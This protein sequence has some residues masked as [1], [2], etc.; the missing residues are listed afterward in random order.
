VRADYAKE[1]LKE[2]GPVPAEEP[3]L[4]MDK[5]GERLAFERAGARLYE[6]LLSKFDAYGSFP[7][8]PTRDDIAHILDEE[9]RH[10]TML[11]ELIQT[12][13]G[14]PTE[15]TPS[16]N[17]QLVASQGV[18]QVLVDPRTNLIQSLEA[19]AMAELTDNECWETLAGLARLAG[20]EDLAERCEDA[21]LTEEEHLEKVRTWLAAGQG[22]MEVEADGVEERE[23]RRKPRRRG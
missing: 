18:G 7:G 22:R 11:A 20:Q 5:L 23:R 21:L 6:A 13:G 2:A 19:I 9:M 15:L 10:F 14:D 3:T 4:L 12:M 16:A 17:V 8:G 1:G